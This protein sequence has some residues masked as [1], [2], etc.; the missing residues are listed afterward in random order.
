MSDHERGGG[1][2]T[3]PM[4]AAL[5]AMLVAIGLAVD[6]VRAAQGVAT[7]DA[8]AEEAARAAAQSLDSA[9]LARGLVVLD[10]EAAVAAARAY[11]AGAGVTGTAVVLGPDRVR[12]EVTVTQPTVLLGIVGHDELVSTGSAEAVV[13]PVAAGQEAPG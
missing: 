1:A 2:L 5:L 6:G 8:L 7:A 10:T 3:A 11:L 12:V 9:A 4:A 13:V